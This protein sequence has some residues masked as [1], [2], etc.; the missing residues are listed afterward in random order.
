MTEGFSEE[1]K[2]EWEEM[3]ETVRTKVQPKTIKN[4][5]VSRSDLVKALEMF[6]KMKAEKEKKIKIEDE[7]KIEYFRLI[8]QNSEF[9]ALRG[10]LT[11][12]MTVLELTGFLETHFGYDVKKQTSAKCL[13]LEVKELYLN[14][15]R[16][17]QE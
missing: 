3:L 12:N 17:E 15:E 5:T 8:P 10:R 4:N 7:G 13:E 16:S 2:R 6:N 1:K 14:I 9:D 11:L